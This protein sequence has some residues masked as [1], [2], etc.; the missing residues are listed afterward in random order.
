[1]KVRPDV[2]QFLYDDDIFMERKLEIGY[3]PKCLKLLAKIT[4]R[5]KTD[6]RYFEGAYSEDKAKRLIQDCSGE[7]MYTSDDARQD[8]VLH[9]WIYGENKESVNKKTGQVITTQKACDFYGTKK[10]IKQEKHEQL[11]Y[12]K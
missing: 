1:M 4:E 5:R 7:I 12:H 11:N 3:C 2:I 10:T 8:K 9:G 6:G